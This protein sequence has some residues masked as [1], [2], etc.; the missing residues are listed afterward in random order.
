MSN[1][2]HITQAYMIQ[3]IFS[4]IRL[5]ITKSD[6]ALVFADVQ[7]NNVGLKKAPTREPFRYDFMCSPSEGFSDSDLVQRFALS[8]REFAA[9]E[10]FFQRIG[11][12]TGTYG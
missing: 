7:F 1:E 5:D 4:L 3:F 8:F 9:L 11:I 6:A 2:I 12:A 10:R